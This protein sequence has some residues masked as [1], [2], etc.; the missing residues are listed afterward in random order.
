MT[1]AGIAALR[2]L[3]LD[4]VF[5]CACLA[6]VVAYGFGAFPLSP[7]R[8]GAAVALLGAA[9][10][11]LALRRGPARGTLSIPLA[12]VLGWWAASF[13]WATTTWAWTIATWRTVPA[14]V[15]LMAMGAVVPAARAAPGLVIGCY[16][17][18][19]WTALALVLDPSSATTNP[20]GAIGWRGRFAHRNGLGMFLALALPT[21]AMLERRRAARAIGLATGLGL[22]IMSRSLTAL[23]TPVA[24]SAVGIWLGAYRARDGRPGAAFVATTIVLAG[25][26]LLAAVVLTPVIVPLLGKNLTLTGRTTT[27]AAIGRAVEVRPLTGYGVGVWLDTALP[28]VADIVRALSHDPHHTHNGLLELLFQLGAVGAAL[29]LAVVLQTVVRAW[30]GLGESPDVS[31]WALLVVAMM[32]V[33]SITEPPVL[34]SWLAILAYAVTVTSQPTPPDRDPR[35]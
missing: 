26:A 6:V 25:A 33:T 2:R 1:G 18:I 27:W 17:G 11:A 34:G 14:V 9:A 22:L 35:A 29:Y 4:T 16:V 15:A 10:V 23:L 31:G 24:V 28:P 19:A 7:R 32:A 13:A 20:D 12:L 8:Y 21:I 30:R 3:S 5:A